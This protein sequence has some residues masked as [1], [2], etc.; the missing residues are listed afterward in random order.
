MTTLNLQEYTDHIIPF[1]GAL[2]LGTSGLPWP[3]PGL[4][5][6]QP[7]SELRPAPPE[8]PVVPW[9]PVTHQ[10]GSHNMYM[11]INGIQID[12]YLHICI[13]YYTHRCRSIDR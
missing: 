6:E 8:Q 2:A 5:A 10:C 3:R 1:K 7:L 9:L 12:T 11:D 13:Y 4:R